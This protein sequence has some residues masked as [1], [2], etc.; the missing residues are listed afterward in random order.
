VKKR[1]FW[2]VRRHSLWEEVVVDTEASFEPDVDVGQRRFKQLEIWEERRKEKEIAEKEKEKERCLRV[3]YEAWMAEEARKA[4]RWKI[5]DAKWAE[6]LACEAEEAQRQAEMDIIDI[7]E[8]WC[9]D[10]Y[11]Y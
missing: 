1:A 4:N 8:E 10:E 6:Y 5:W 11:E 9:G 3:E 2:Y 7:K